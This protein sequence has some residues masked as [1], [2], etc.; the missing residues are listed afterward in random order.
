VSLARTPLMLPSGRPENVD[1]Q[2]PPERFSRQCA[3]ELDERPSLP[4]Q[5]ESERL[6]LV[7]Q[8][9]RQAVLDDDRPHKGE[10][11]LDGKLGMSAFRRLADI[12]SIRI[13]VC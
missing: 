13:D 1:P 11:T 5:R 10:R 9:R 6:K 8:A 12:I 3:R 2:M 7:I 4:L